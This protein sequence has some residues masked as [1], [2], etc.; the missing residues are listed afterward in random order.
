MEEVAAKRNYDPKYNPIV[1]L[2]FDYKK[3]KQEK[4]V[5]YP[6]TE[7]E[8]VLQEILSVKKSIEKSVEVF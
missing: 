6:V 5:K 4:A 8:M 2:K 7:Q 1:K 3:Y